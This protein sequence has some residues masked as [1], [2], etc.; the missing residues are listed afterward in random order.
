MTDSATVRTWLA[1]VGWVAETPPC[2]R[3]DLVPPSQR[4]AKS[5][6]TRSRAGTSHP[7]TLA[8]GRTA[9][10]GA[11]FVGILLGS[12]TT[13][14]QEWL[15][16]RLVSE[17]GWL[18]CNDRPVESSELSSV[19]PYGASRWVGAVTGRVT[20]YAEVQDDSSLFILGVPGRRRRP[21]RLE[22][23]ADTWRLPVYEGTG[24]RRRLGPGHCLRDGWIV[25]PTRNLYAEDGA[26][27]RPP[28]FGRSHGLATRVDSVS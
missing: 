8:L 7:H 4:S 27:N 21:V 12:T 19:P 16:L 22:V 17:A 23:P 24:E 28:G 1:P 13:R 10:G 3:R 18:L 11:G 6:S 2:T 26:C 14:E 25:S 15:V 5:A 9:W 20:L